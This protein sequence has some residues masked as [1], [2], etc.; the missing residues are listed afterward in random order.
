MGGESYVFPLMD[1]VASESEASFREMQAP[2]WNLR[3]VPSVHLHAMDP[4]SLKELTRVILHGWTVG[5]RKRGPG[6]AVEG[7]GIAEMASTRL[8]F[9]V[10]KLEAHKVPIL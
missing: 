9:K 5:L 2:R 8:K 10:P 6:E 7:K 3:V 4:H 1:F